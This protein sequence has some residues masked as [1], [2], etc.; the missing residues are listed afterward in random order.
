MDTKFRHLIHRAKVVMEALPYLIKFHNQVMVI[1]YGGAAM[2]DPILKQQ[3]MQDI[4]LLKFIGIHP[5]VVHG[6]GPEINKALE[7]NK[8]PTHFVNGQRYSSKEVLAVVEKVLGGEINHAICELLKTAG[9][10]PKGFSGSNGKIIRAK[11]L[12]LE[13]EKGASLD[14]GYIGKVEGVRYRTLMKFVKQGYIPVLAPIGVGRGGQCFNINADLAAAGVASSIKAKK[15]ILM[16]DTYGVLDKQGEL[17]SS[18]NTASA[19]KMIQQ[20]IISG[21]MIPK[22]NCGLNAI[23]NG[24]E[25]VH[26]IDGRIPHAVLLEIFTDVGIGTMVVG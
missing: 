23:K 19:K 24:V 12:Y 2:K 4:V 15:L 5:I 22:V 3:V 11:K 20:K 17:I 1:K 10:R 8:I 6:G 16:T 9:G 18:I 7:K 13:D 26:I 25:K 14:L 21:G